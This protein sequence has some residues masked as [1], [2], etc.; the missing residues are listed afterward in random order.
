MIVLGMLTVINPVIADPT[1][2]DVIK[3]ADKALSDKQK[4]VDIRDLRIANY[5]TLTTNLNNENTTLKSQVDAWY[6]SP[7]LWILV[8]AV[9]GGY[10][11]SK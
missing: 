2:D 10:L 3:S 4:Q 7:Y 6:R 9:V 11:K 8:G 1:C 5:D